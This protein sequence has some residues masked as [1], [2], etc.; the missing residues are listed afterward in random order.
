MAVVVDLDW[1][2]DADLNRDVLSTAILAGYAQKKFLTG[3]QIFAKTYDVVGL[4]AIELEGLGC[5]SLVELEREDAHADEVGSVDTLVAGGNDCFHAEETCSFGGPITAAAGAVF[6]TSDDD[7]RGL[8]RLILA[9]GVVDAHALVIGLV[10]SLTT[11]HAGKHEVFDAHVGKS[12]AGH[13]AVI[14]SAAAIAVEVILGDSVFAEEAAC[15]GLLLDG[16]S[17][18]DMIGR[19][20]VTEDAQRTGS[21]DRS[22]H[23]GFHTEVFEEGGLLD[24]GALGIPLIDLSGRGTDLVPLGILSCEIAVQCGKHLRCEGAAQCVANLGEAGPDVLEEDLFPFLAFADRLLGEVYVNS[25]CQR[26]GDH[27]GGGHQEVGLDIL[28]NAG[29]K[30]TVA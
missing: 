13:D 29:L 4:G 6:L 14:A 22:D 1:G 11:L 30:V 16:S 25:T 15:W 3:L 17:R 19:N 12:A 23:A 2:I 5:C 28:V 7:E 26:E 20:R 21:G 9:R 18:R 8:L 10:E 27:K 24:V